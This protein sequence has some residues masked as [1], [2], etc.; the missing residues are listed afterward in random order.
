[1]ATVIGVTAERAAQIEGNSVVGG[2]ISGN[3]L[4]LTRG[5]GTQFSAGQVIFPTTTTNMWAAVNSFVYPVG[6]LYFNSQNATNPA[7]LLGGGT[8][9]AFGAGRVPVGYDASQGEF[10]AAEKVS[11]SKTYAMTVNEMPSHN[12]GGVPN[13]D[14]PDHSHT[15]GGL[16]SEDYGTHDWAFGDISSGRRTFTVHAAVPTGGASTRHQ[17]GVFSQGGSTPVVGNN[18]QPS[19]VVYIWK[20]TA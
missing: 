19:I 13:D 11:G 18:L 14:G 16:Y 10:N 20:R 15:T 3:S 7:T 17:H 5:N 12:H 6:S 8:W 2:S 1:M 9:A 4:F